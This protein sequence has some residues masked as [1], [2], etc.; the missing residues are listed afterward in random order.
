LAPLLNID[1]E[2]WSDDTGY[3][4]VPAEPGWAG[5]SLLDKVSGL[6]G[7]GKEGN[8]P[9]RIVRRGGKLV[10]YRPFERVNGLYRIFANIR[11]SIDGL[12][13]FIYRFGPLTQGGL[14]PTI[15][16]EVP[17]VLGHASAMSDLLAYSPDGRISYLSQFELSWTR[18]DVGLVVNRFTGKPQI[19]LTPPSLLH[20]LWLEFG[21]A[22]SGDISIKKCAHCGGWFEVGPGTGKR[23][24]AKFCCSDHRVVFNSRKRNKGGAEHA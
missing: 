10:P 12:L 3:D 23:E 16:D 2:W 19:T 5:M 4:Y 17:A 9:D 11:T 20:G 6:L 15:G 14:D 7:G 21:Q 24:D 13:D 1:F 8:R 18:I 22:L